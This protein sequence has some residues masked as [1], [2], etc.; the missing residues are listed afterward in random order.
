MLFSNHIPNIRRLIA[1]GEKVTYI[2]RQHPLYG[3]EWLLAA[4]ITLGLSLGFGL[5]F[6]VL[7]WLLLAAS[8]GLFGI[9][10]LPFYF[11]EMAVTTHRFLAQQGRWHVEMIEILPIHLDHWDLKQNVFLGLI[12][13]GHLTLH[14]RSG[15]QLRESRFNWI[16]DP[17]ELLSHLEKLSPNNATR[18]NAEGRPKL[19]ATVENQKTAPHAVEPAPPVESKTEAKTAPGTAKRPPKTP[20]AITGQH[21]APGLKG[22]SQVPQ[23]PKSPLA[24]TF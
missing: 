19:P 23:K 12:R 13:A 3:W 21:F 15:M 17:L 8:I 16:D 1:E 20:P 4:A 10:A 5:H 22:P 11:F 24:N 18:L 9:Y 2:G 14:L 6:P 7:G